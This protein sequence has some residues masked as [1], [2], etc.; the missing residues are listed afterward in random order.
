MLPPY[1]AWGQ[2]Q[3]SVA[4]TSPA[5]P[6]AMPSPQPV[7]T[8][9]LA[10]VSPLIQQAAYLLPRL[11]A[12]QQALLLLIAAVGKRANGHPYFPEAAEQGDMHVLQHLQLVQ[13]QGQGVLL[14]PMADAV[15]VAERI[16]RLIALA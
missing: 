10:R 4:Q 3:P 14:T 5:S 11:T 13:F 2:T 12:T 1:G 16:T 15:I 9:P 7:P 8:D 6:Y